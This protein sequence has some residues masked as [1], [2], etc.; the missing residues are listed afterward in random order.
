[1][2]AYRPASP[3]LELGRR[4]R[5]IV[6]IL[7]RLG[8]ASVAQ[9]RDE[10]PDPP[11]YSAVRGMLNLLAGKKLIVARQ[12]GKRY[13]YRAVASKQRIGLSALKSLVRTFFSD[14]P[15]DA[16]AALLDGSAG[17]LTDDDLRS[18]RAL[19]EKAEHARSTPSKH[20][21]EDKS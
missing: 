1:M 18:I 6:E 12:Q 11:T 7:Y 14:A 16:V 5:Q 20:H 3:T 10:L 15:V 13:L 9:V 17:K 2:A 19:I 8:E 4:E 21:P